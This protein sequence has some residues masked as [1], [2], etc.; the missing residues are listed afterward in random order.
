MSAGKLSHIE[1]RAMKDRG[2]PRDSGRAVT[3]YLINYGSSPVWYL[4]EGVRREA[5]SWVR[6]RKLHHDLPES[7]FEAS[8]DQI[9]STA[10]ECAY[11]WCQQLLMK[12]TQLGHHEDAQVATEMEQ[13]FREVFNQAEEIGKL[14]TY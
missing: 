10:F 2:A 13:K 5:E 9:R 8:W 11:E 3:S 12:A 4:V 7:E 1:L 14:H 6:T